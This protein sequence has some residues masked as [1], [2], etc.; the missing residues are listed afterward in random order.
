MSGRI[1]LEGVRDLKPGETLCDDGKGA[2]SGLGARRQRGDAV[3]YVLK[4][5]TAEGRQRW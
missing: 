3:S 2:V 4:Y 1:T 5:R